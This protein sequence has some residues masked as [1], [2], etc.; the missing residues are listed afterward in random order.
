MFASVFR[1]PDWLKTL[2]KSPEDPPSG[3]VS[4][5]VGEA[6][7]LSAIC[8]GHTVE[9]VLMGAPDG[10]L[11]YTPRG[12]IEAAATVRPPWD[13]CQYSFG[14]LMPRINWA[15]SRNEFRASGALHVFWP[16]GGP[17]R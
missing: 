16:A 1:V 3:V 10:C 15:I 7:L 4:L 12:V 14:G 17:P 5:W 6:L 9:S 2:R 11:Y 13:V 8:L